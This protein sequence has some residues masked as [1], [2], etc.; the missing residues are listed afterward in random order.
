M[1]TEDMTASSSEPSEDTEHLARR[2]KAE[3]VSPDQTLQH[4]SG[5]VATLSRPD[6]STELRLSQPWQCPRTSK[7]IQVAPQNIPAHVEVSKAVS[8]DCCHPQV[9]TV[10]TGQIT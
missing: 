1:H 8:T 3:Q 7:T 10:T 4:A 2:W 5:S 9:L 6:Q